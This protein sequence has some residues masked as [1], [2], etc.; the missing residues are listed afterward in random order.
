MLRALT[1]RQEDG[2]RRDPGSPVVAHLFGK[3]RRGEDHVELELPR[4][5][6]LRSQDD[7]SLRVDYF[8]LCFV[9]GHKHFSKEPGPVDYPVPKSSLLRPSHYH[10]DVGPQNWALSLDGQGDE[11]DEAEG[12]GAGPLT[13]E[14]SRQKR[15][16][17]RPKADVLT[18]DLQFTTD[19][20]PSRPLQ[21]AESAIVTP[22]MLVN[23]LNGLYW[24]MHRDEFL[25]LTA[26][27]S[28]TFY[29]LESSKRVVV[30]LPPLAVA[31]FDH[32]QV[33]WRLLGFR[34]FPAGADQAADSE[35]PLRL[36]AKGDLCLVNFSP[37]K[38]RL[39]VSDVSVNPDAP[40]HPANTPPADILALTEI[41]SEQLRVYLAR[42]RSS[43]SVSFDFAGQPNFRQVVEGAPEEPPPLLTA[44]LL[45]A[46]SSLVFDAASFAKVFSYDDEAE[47]KAGVVTRDF[48]FG[49]TDYPSLSAPPLHRLASKNKMRLTFKAGPGAAKTLGLKKTL[50][51]L[52]VDAGVGRAPTGTAEFLRA[53]LTE[54]DSWD[55]LVDG[56]MAFA[57]RHTLAIATAV[58]RDV[59][60]VEQAKEVTAKAA[61]AQARCNLY[62]RLSQSPKGLE[63][64]PEAVVSVLENS[65]E[66]D[67]FEFPVSD[68]QLIEKDVIVPRHW[69]GQTQ[70]D[71]K[72]RVVP[73]CPLAWDQ[74][75]SEGAWEVLVK[76]EEGIKKQ[77]AAEAQAVLDAAA[78]AA[79]GVAEGG[80]QPIDPAQ[81]QQQP[82]QQQQLDPGLAEA[83]LDPGEGEAAGPAV[84]A[85]AV[86]LDPPPA[87][88][89]EYR[90]TK[91]YNSAR[92]GTLTSSALGLCPLPPEELKLPDS[93]YLL[94]EEGERRDWMGPLGPRSLLGRFSKGYVKE[95]REAVLRGGGNFK[96]LTFK[97]A[98]MGY[99]IFTAPSDP[100]KVKEDGLAV[101]V[102]RF[103]PYRDSSVELSSS[104]H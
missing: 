51:P 46:A 12:G 99:D 91:N 4:A 32:A 17:P 84:A 67:D 86:A 93:F 83:V 18:V 43:T 77:V 29:I 37:F 92:A 71:S 66:V 95:P 7:Y 23:T 40:V 47:L 10:F 78:Q 94:V 57:F 102:C 64:L 36:V 54:P 1:V 55:P 30:S 88:P 85:A 65:D 58:A 26:G 89:V 44:L 87:A 70:L 59:T 42:A 33:L 68:F 24:N 13:T 38:T 34:R 5:L 9:D 79:A 103:H 90:T 22:Q 53:G 11:E 73:V 100:A 16:A 82:P 25:G 39:Y 62:K 60:V 49:V 31:Y 15:Q 101:A 61:L 63:G 21:A 6:Q 14:G 81:E 80:A 50:F 75:V 8:S 19:R 97:V 3:M 45:N 41:L 52:V 96:S 48:A 72:N 56:D 98:G 27:G 104:S 74:P 28:V 35:L 2:L 20:I 69:L 76:L